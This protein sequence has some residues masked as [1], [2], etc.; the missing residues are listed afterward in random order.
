MR[1]SVIVPVYNK[2]PFLK[3]CF[4]SI[5]SQSLSDFE[6]IAV[7]DCSTDGSLE[8][9]RGIDD[10]RLKVHALD[11]NLG[12]AGAAQRAI[13]L[14]Q[15]DYIIR[16]D[17]DDLCVPHRFERQLDFMLRRPGLIASGSHLKL[18]GDADELWPYPIGEDRCRAELL[19][20]NPV[21]QGASIIDAR[22]IRQAG[23]RYADDWPRIGEDWIYWAHCSAHGGFDN[24]DEPLLLYRRS[25]LNSDVGLDRTAYRERIIRAV[26]AVLGLPLTDDDAISHLM[27]LR[28]FKGEPDSARL[29]AVRDWMARLMA[30]NAERGVLPPAAL[31]QRLEEAWSHLFYI[32]SRAHP[33]LA[34]KHW[35][36]GPDRS[37]QR[38][39]Y[40]AKVTVNRVIGR[41]PEA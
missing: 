13:D 28:S 5:F 27:L 19:F 9:L 20:N 18:F 39:G 31:A 30:V 33:Q 2:A 37:T 23:I 6:V 3:E 7:D 16:V 15:G 22:R 29:R 14:A 35:L 11:R 1:L 10:R 41:N 34:L 25:A 8:R 4:D 40:L 36:M 32:L 17:A 26:F 21:S 38:L 24:I 12:P